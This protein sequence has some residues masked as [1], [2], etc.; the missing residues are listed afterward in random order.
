MFKIPIWGYL[1]RACGAVP[2]SRQ[3]ALEAL[4]S[5]GLVMVAPGGVREAMTSAAHDYLLTWHGKQGF[6]QIAAQAKVPVIPMFTRNVREVFLVLGG[7]LPIV[8]KLYKLTRLPFTPFVGPLPMP[9]TSVL[10][11]PIPHEEG[12]EPSV[13]AGRVHDALQR[14]MHQLA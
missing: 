14:L 13:L 6:A 10:G 1:C 7:S 5:G 12:I 8:Q 3:A 11:A 2:A 9:L 4:K